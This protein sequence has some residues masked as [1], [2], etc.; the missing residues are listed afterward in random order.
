MRRSM[1]YLI[2]GSMTD[3]KHSILAVAV[4][5]FA[6]TMTASAGLGKEP[7]STPFIQIAAPW[8]ELNQPTRR[9]TM[10]RRIHRDGSWMP[11]SHALQ[12]K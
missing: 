6:P 9:K 7:P 2:Y 12:L 11:K 4:D 10:Y 8:L 5:R 3:Y 1:A